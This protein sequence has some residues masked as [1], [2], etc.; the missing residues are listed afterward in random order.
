M[1]VKFHWSKFVRIIT[2]LTLLLVVIIPV[3]LAIG[4]YID[5]CNLLLALVI[6]L[7]IGL[8][9]AFIIGACA[10]WAYGMMPVSMSIIGENERCVYDIN[11]ENV[12]GGSDVN[13]GNLNRVNAAVGRGVDGA[14]GNASG[15]SGEIVV[16]QG[17]GRSIVIPLESIV[18]IE[19]L[20]R[21]KVR[22]AF[23]IRTYGSGGLFGW[24]GCFYNKKLGHYE[25]YA[26]E[27]RNLII[28]KTVK[29]TYVFSCMEREAFLQK[30]ADKI[31]AAATS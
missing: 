29:K 23:N 22:G 10:W 28:I 11:I 2:T 4:V 27:L 24:L 25:M 31:A 3:V 16:R 26:T 15:S 14:V 19:S 1:T 13:R 30:V 21:E 9:T 17:R 18:S 6:A 12:A 8:A 5:S 20:P 7:S